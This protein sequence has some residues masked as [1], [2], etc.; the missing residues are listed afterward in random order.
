MQCSLWRFGNYINGYRNKNKLKTPKWGLEQI[1]IS[2]D[3]CLWNTACEK[4]IKSSWTNSY[5]VVIKYGDFKSLFVKYFGG[6][7]EKVYMIICLD[8]LLYFEHKCSF[9]KV[10]H[11]LSKFWRTYF[12]NINNAV[13]RINVMFTIFWRFMLIF[14][15]KIGAFLNQHLICTF[16]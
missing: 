8:E 7:L 16:A 12:Q 2:W 3:V 6:F 15:E 5:L 10:C 1:H 4:K 13:R 14:G 11:F 9:S